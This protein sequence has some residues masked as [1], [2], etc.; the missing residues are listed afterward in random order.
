MASD[1]VLRRLYLKYNR[2]YFDNKLP[3]DVHVYWHPTPDTCV[4]WTFEEGDHLAIQMS[5]GIAGFR[6][7]FKW[8]LIHEMVHIALWKGKRERVMHGPS[9]KKELLRVI[10][11]GAIRFL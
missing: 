3:L 9:F 4:A 5:P 8:I 2:D 10:Q 11:A 1:S 6:R 7:Y